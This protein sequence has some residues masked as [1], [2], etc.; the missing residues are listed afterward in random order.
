MIAIALLFAAADVPQS[1]LNAADDAN[2]AYTQCMFA[3][4]R[5]ANQA[6]VSASGFESRLRSNCSAEAERL[7]TVSARIFAARGHANPAA[8]ADRMMEEDYR[9]SV[10]EYRQLPEKEKLIRDFCK[11]DPKDCG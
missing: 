10:E 7:S 4:M 8:E 6:H 1:L 9:S 5:A 11:A 3:T 2:L